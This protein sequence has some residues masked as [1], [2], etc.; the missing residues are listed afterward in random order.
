[1][2]SGT[3][4]THSRFN[5]SIIK[6]VRFLQIWRIHNTKKF[7]PGCREKH[8]SRSTKQEILKSTVYPNDKIYQDVKFY[9]AVLNEDNYVNHN[10]ENNQSLWF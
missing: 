4:I 9:V 7:E 6:S 5:A 10:S 1:M 8:F 2:L 3:V